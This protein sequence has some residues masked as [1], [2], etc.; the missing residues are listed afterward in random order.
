[1]FLDNVQSFIYNIFLLQGSRIANHMLSDK[2][3]IMHVD[4][5]M[6]QGGKNIPN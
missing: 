3:R 2:C 6:L 4:A 1:M 5:P